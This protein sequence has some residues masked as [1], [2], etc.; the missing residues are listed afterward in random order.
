METKSS[1]EVASHFGGV[2]Q[3]TEEYET[4]KKSNY[5]KF[6]QTNEINIQYSLVDFCGQSFLKQSEVNKIK[7]LTSPRAYHNELMKHKPHTDFLLGMNLKLKDESIIVC[8][9]C[10]DCMVIY[11]I[12]LR[13]VTTQRV[14]FDEYTR[15]LFKTFRVYFD[16]REM[17]RDFRKNKIDYHRIIKHLSPMFDP[18]D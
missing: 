8:M 6:K 4:F 5:D 17:Q 7:I 10:M 13:D 14:E 11:G 18:E 1:K 16:W 15:V 2:Y 3:G 9:M 12:P